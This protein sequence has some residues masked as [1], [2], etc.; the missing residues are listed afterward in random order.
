MLWAV[1]LAVT[2]LSYSEVI[3]P[4]DAQKNAEIGIGSHISEVADPA[5]R[6]ALG[7]SSLRMAAMEA[8]IAELRAELAARDNSLQTDTNEMGK[9]LERLSPTHA[10]GR[11]GDSSDD[12]LERFM[13]SIRAE[14]AELKTQCSQ[15]NEKQA[16]TPRNNGTVHK[17]FS[18]SSSRHRKQ[19]ASGSCD[20][21]SWASRT[22]AVTDACCS[23][24]GGTGTGH[25][26]AQGTSCSMPATCPSA[27][28]AAEFVPYYQDC[29]AELQ[30]HA[31]EL[32]LDEFSAFYAS[33]QEMQSGSG[34]LL[35]PVAVQMFRVRVS[36]EGAA[37]AGA[38][39]P[40]AGDGGGDGQLP[41]LDPLHP[42]VPLPP[43]P[44]PIGQDLAVGGVE[45]FHADCSSVDVAT[46][47]PQCNPEHHG[48][49]LLATID[50]TDTKF[51]CNVAH[52]LYSWMGAASEGGY[53]G[54]DA[55]AFLSAVLSHAAGTFVCQIMLSTEVST[56]VDLITG[57]GATLTGG[58]STVWTFRGEGAAFSVGAQASLEI[59]SM[60][61]AATSGLAFRIDAGAGLSTSLVQLQATGSAAAP[62]SCRQ[63]GMAMGM[64]GLNCDQLSADGSGTVSVLGPIFISTS[65][66]G[67]GMGSTKYMGDDVT[68]FKVA[69][70]T[71]EP[72][73]YT[74]QMTDAS[75]ASPLV[76]A[77]GSAMRVS[78]IGDES[79]P[80]WVFTGAGSAFSVAQYGHLNLA[81]I[82]LSPSAIAGGA[83]TI[84][85]ALGGEVS[86]DHSQV[87]DASF[88]VYGTLSMSATHATDI[89]LRTDHSA[90]VAMDAMTLVGM[91]AP[92][93]LPFACE[94]TITRSQIN[95]VQLQVDSSGDLTVTGST[96]RSEGMLVAVSSGGVFSV[97]SSQLVHDGVIDAFPCN[98]QNMHCM[99]DHAGSVVVRGPASINTVAPLVCADESAESCMSGYVDIPSCLADIASG[100]MSCFIYLRA[101]ARGLGAVTVDVGQSFEV[102]GAVG[103]VALL[104]V[105]A[106]WEVAT[107]ALLVLADLW[108]AGGTGD[109]TAVTVQTGG[110][111]SL[112]RIEIQ[113]G[114]VTFSGA[115]TVTGCTLTNAQLI[116]STVAAML[117]VSGGTLTGSTVSLSGAS[118]VLDGSCTLI[119]SPV[120]ITD[121]TLSVS[122]C[123]LQSDGSS[124]PLMVESGASAT[125]TG[126]VFRSSAGDITALSVA[127]G[128]SLTV[129]DSQLVGADGSSDPFPCDGA[130]PN[131]AGTHD[132]AVDVEGPSAINMAAPLVCDATTGTY[133]ASAISA[134]L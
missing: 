115:L 44:P 60:A 124:V 66:I 128:G 31:D 9:T 91:D 110:E 117:S 109:A 7:A 132:G 40:T 97:A 53:I 20:G 12:V 41:A 46:C 107:A 65:G 5:V 76:L 43:P 126:V 99:T 42:I 133:G 129:G 63:L 61:V 16:G 29:G 45:Q 134:L 116:G 25:R 21:A 96:F 122:Q 75:P 80:A 56:A 108:L 23:P 64:D 48:F 89:S 35:Q 69:V 121:G 93:V 83:S 81:Y 50:G 114:A 33:C 34:M 52:G 1:C 102:H 8:S 131:C 84:A 54:S 119:N 22:Q 37:Q 127:E 19:A 79:L 38:M 10:H 57:Q 6:L 101:D 36:T 90:S 28:C 55:F 92:L 118:A 3:A 94:S 30:G 86:I 47:V 17:P 4:T 82:T 106:D 78:I 14:M 103:L 70:S 74:L 120:S 111:L 39:F 72:G 73:L 123:E 71:A 98:G 125:V 130:L 2:L 24:A 13:A 77:V 32:P 105:E 18:T 85:I 51:S 100:M 88:T 49:E 59:H 27:S 104:E 15:T 87:Q 11:D 26:R 58:L 68:A 95:N 112:L 67:F 62:I 113:S